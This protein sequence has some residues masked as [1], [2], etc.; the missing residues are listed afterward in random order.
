[1]TQPALTLE[2][3]L[4]VADKPRSYG[5]TMEAWR[6]NC[7][8]MP[9]WENAVSEGLVRVEPGGPMRERKVALTPQG[10]ALLAAGAGS[11]PVKLAP[12]E[13]A[14]ADF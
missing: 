9:I 7:P 3:L 1:M 14:S 2:F 12:A 6:T 11:S 4:W 8:R 13:E 10:R 5:D